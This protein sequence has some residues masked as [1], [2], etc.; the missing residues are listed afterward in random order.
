MKDIFDPLIEEQMK[1]S[2]TNKEVETLNYSKTQLDRHNL[3][4]MPTDT[5]ERKNMYHQKLMHIMIVMYVQ[6]DFE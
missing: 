4:V 2:N 6:T 3:M 5:P 1:A